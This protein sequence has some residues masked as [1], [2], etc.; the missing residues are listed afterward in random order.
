[1][2]DKKTRSLIVTLV[3]IVFVLMM[4]LVYFLFF[5]DKENPEIP[6]DPIVIPN[7][8]IVDYDLVNYE[9]YDLNELS[10][11]FVLVD[12]RIKD[13]EAINI[14]LSE[15]TTSDG[16]NL[17]FVSDEISE[18]ADFS[19]FLGKVGVDFDIESNDKSA[20]FTLF[21]PIKNRS[22]KEIDLFLNDSKITIDL[23]KNITGT[24]IKIGIS[25]NE[26][27]TDDETFRIFVSAAI[28]ITGEAL[29]QNNEISTYPST[30]QLMAFKLVLESLNEEMIMIEE[31][32]Y[33]TEKNSDTFI[34]LDGT[35]TKTEK[36]INII[37]I[38]TDDRAEGY[39]F[40]MT[41][42]P[43]REKMTYSGI[44]RVKI[45]GKWS[46]VAIKL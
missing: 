42:N 33:V 44:L 15:F 14:S 27:I 38:K 19:V 40:F 24:A 23:T 22:E 11:K 13:K 17:N 25:H 39:L 18:L 30:A 37:N 34:A 20:L 12:V 9:V 31:A 26:N 5:N 8:D 10:F 28:D 43:E 32:E 21:V 45:N 3:V 6:D 2:R 7:E 16:T 46:S 4:S 36:R 41:L 35:Y 29:Y 1:M